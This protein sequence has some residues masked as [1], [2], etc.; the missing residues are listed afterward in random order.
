MHG[1]S[2]EKSLPNAPI[3]RAMTVASSDLRLFFSP[4]YEDRVDRPHICLILG[5]RECFEELSPEREV[6]PVEILRDP[7]F[8][9][10][11]VT[12]NKRTPC[13]DGWCARCTPR[14]CYLPNNAPGANPYRGSQVQT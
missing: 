10:H 3:D 11:G 7:F 1:H 12:R 9:C 13:P 5:G 6:R 2:D 8:H 4:L 14:A